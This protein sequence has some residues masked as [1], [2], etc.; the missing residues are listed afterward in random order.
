[1]LDVGNKSIAYTPPIGALRV[2]VN[3]ASNLKNLEKI[4]KIDPYAKILVN[5][6]QRGRTD[7]DA[8]TTNPVWNTGV[9]VALTSPNQRITLECM[10]V[11]TSNKDRTLGQFDIKLNDFFQKNSLDRY[12]TKVDSTQRQGRLTAKFLSSQATLPLSGI[13]LS[14]VSVK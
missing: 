4:G 1:M 13:D 7:F 10:D 8:Q 11:E 2:F 14:V 6:I 3:K 9:Y 5:G 12:D